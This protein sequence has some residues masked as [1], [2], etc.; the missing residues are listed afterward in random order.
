MR[1]AYRSGVPAQ[2][3]KYSAEWQG[4]CGHQ[5]ATVKLLLTNADIMAEANSVPL[6]V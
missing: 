6:R 3:T 5:P 4:V 2:R 1:D